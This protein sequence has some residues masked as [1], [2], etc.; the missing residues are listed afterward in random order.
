MCTRTAMVVAIYERKRASVRQTVEIGSDWAD[1]CTHNEQ[2]HE[3]QVHHNFQAIIILFLPI[4][5]NIQ[6]FGPQQN[7]FILLTQCVY[8]C[9]YLYLFSICKSVWS[10]VNSFRTLT[11]TI[12]K[13][14]NNFTNFTT[15]GIS[16]VKY[17]HE[18]NDKM[19]R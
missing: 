19:A 6:I 18:R 17:S 9:L 10:M 8:I 5:P 12:N 3:V 14:S 15:H 2:R 1:F 11:G 13:M 16:F 7:W 4:L